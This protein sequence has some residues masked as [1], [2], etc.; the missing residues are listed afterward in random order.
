MEGNVSQYQTGFRLGS[1]N[2]AVE[3]T[4]GAQPAHRTTFKRGDGTADEKN[5]NPEYGALRSQSSTDMVA[6]Q[7]KN[8]LT[9]FHTLSQ[10]R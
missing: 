2:K 7:C 4:T 9:V 8:E 5:D 10:Y 3:N 1:K 6:D